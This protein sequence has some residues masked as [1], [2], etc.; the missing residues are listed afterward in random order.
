M[1]KLTFN[2]NSKY[3]ISQLDPYDYERIQFALIN[4]EPTVTVDKVN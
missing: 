1:L 3:H 2:F 4:M